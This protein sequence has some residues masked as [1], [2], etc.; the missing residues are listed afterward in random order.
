MAF[1]LL[2]AMIFHSSSMAMADVARPNE[3]RVVRARYSIGVNNDYLWVVGS[4]HRI[5]VVIKELDRELIARGWEKTVAYGSFRLCAH[6]IR[7][8]MLLTGKDRVLVAG[9]SNISF[10]RE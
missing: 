8:P 9:Y 7:N 6:Q 4:K 5:V 10:V 2:T 3:C 1:G